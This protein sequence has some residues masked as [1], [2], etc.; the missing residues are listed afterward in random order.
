VLAASP[1]GAVDLQGRIGALGGARTNMGVLGSRYAIGALTGLEAQLMAGWLGVVWSLQY[2]YFPSSD[3]RNVESNLDLWDLD[4][5]LR[6]RVAIRPDGP[7]FFFGQ[8]GVDLMRASVPLEPDLD[9]SYVGPTVR[10]GGELVLGTIVLSLSAD[11]GLIVGGPSG[12]RLLLFAGL[13]G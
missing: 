2:T 5:G 11:Y 3:P 12:L 1:A 13:G 6:A 7:A 10:I 8:L 4:F 9:T